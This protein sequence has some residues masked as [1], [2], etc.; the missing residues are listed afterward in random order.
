MVSLRGRE[1]S[2]AMSG[3]DFFCRLSKCCTWISRLQKSV[4]TCTCRDSGRLASSY[5]TSC[6]S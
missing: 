4:D 3:H 6:I 2:E 5:E 1:E